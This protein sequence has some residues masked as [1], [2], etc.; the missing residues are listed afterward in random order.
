MIREEFF[1][2]LSFFH[3]D[4]IWL[5][6]PPPSPSAPAC[7]GTLLDA[8]KNVKKIK[9]DTFLDVLSMGDGHILGLLNSTGA[10]RSG[11]R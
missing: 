2:F 6:A 4:S 8:I 1:F 3:F 5:A 10:N 7:S 9:V 11:F